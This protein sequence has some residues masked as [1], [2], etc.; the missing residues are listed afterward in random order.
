MD[1]ITKAQNSLIEG[2]LQ[3]NSLGCPLVLSDTAS[4]EFILGLSRSPLCRDS[5]CS[6]Y[7]RQKEGEKRDL[8]QCSEKEKQARPTLTPNCQQASLAKYSRN[9]NLWKGN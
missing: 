2:R 8:R 7:P 1:M 5:L 6:L 9:F 4:I 3:S